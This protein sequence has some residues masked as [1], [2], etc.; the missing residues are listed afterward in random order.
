LARKQI[1][2]AQTAIEKDRRRIRRRYKVNLTT[3]KRYAPGEENFVADLVVVLTLAGFSRTQI[4]RTVG[5]SKGQTKEL[6]EAPDVAERIVALRD[7]L[8]QAALDLIHTYMIE[9]VQAIADVMRTSQRDE[10]ILKAA[11]E[12]LDR[13]GAAKASRTEQDIHK[14][15]ES[16]TTFSSEGMVE[17]IRQLP[18]EKQ[19]EAAQMIENVENFLIEQANT[20]SKE[21]EP[22]E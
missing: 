20:K 6:L 13:G 8:P 15:E 12:I 17:A 19:E 10:M 1:P 16:R 11:A 3:R 22:E 2:Q 7:R 5:I 9:A 21:K 14:V 4:A 18:P